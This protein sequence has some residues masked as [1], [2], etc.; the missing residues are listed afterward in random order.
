M[1]FSI[2]Q[3]TIAGFTL[4]LAL[5]L[6]IGG[7]SYGN[8][9]RIHSRLQHVTEVSTPMVISASQLL[10][11]LRENQLKVIDYQTTTNLHLLALKKVDVKSRTPFSSP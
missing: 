1:S 6:I 5:I 9:N 7:I 10:A 11:S 4:M 8:T 2:V 3:R